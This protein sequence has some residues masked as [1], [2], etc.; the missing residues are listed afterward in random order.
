MQMFERSARVG[1]SG[2]WQWGL[3]AGTHQDG[4]NPYAGL[5]THWYHNNCEGSESELQVSPDSFK[6][7][8]IEATEHSCVCFVQPGPEFSD[9]ETP[10]VA[11]AAVSKKR[12]KPIP[13]WD[14]VPGWQ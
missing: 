12:P 8:L 13:A 5:P 3:D 1:V 10:L 14:G 4:W 9:N 7:G 11:P 2:H 6:L